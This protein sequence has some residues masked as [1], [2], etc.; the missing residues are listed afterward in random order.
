MDDGWQFRCCTW[1]EAETQHAD[2]LKR[3]RRLRWMATGMQRAVRRLQRNGW[4]CWWT[5]LR[6]WR[7]CGRFLHGQ[8]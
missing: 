7:Q 6:W 3:V 5:P 8:R 4:M 1:D 2:A